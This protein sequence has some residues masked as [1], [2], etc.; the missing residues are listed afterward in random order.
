[1]RLTEAGEVVF[2]YAE[3]IFATGQ[4]L[5]DVLDGRTPGSF[6]EIRIGIADVVPKSLA[7]RLIEPGL[8]PD[9]GAFV[10]CEED[11]TDR[12]LAALA[13]GELDLVISDRPIPA[14]IKVKAFNHFIGE[15]GISFIGAPI[16]ARKYKRTFP[17][18]L[19]VAP[20]ILPTPDSAIRDELGLWFDSLGI[21]PHC[22]G[23]FQDRALMKL[24]AREGKGIIPIPTAM[25]AEVKREFH[26]EVIGRAP[27]VKEQLYVIS[28]ER[29]LRNPLIVRICGN[30][31]R[32]LYA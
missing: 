27:K 22:I 4:E 11:K 1:M 9:S 26:L 3:Q 7:Y 21:T 5:L 15:S 23:A 8:D 29:K 10:R 28:A 19:A 2:S 6:N 30:A 16:F 12:L 31:K 14:T 32:R 18:C 17:K 24:A 13:I 25:E 20:L